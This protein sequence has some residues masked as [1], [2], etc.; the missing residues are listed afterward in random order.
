FDFKGVA[1]HEISEVLG[2]AGLSGG[3]VGGNPGYSLLD[4][5]SYTGPGTKMLGE[6]PN[7]NFSIDNG[8]TLL[9]VFNDASANGLDSRDWASGQSVDAFNQ[10]ASPGVTLPVSA[11]DL[12]VMDVIGYDPVPVPEPA[13]VLALL[14]AALGIAR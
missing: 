4:N 1:A 5:F 10:F 6:G 3:S 7:S 13:G 8:T 14:V 12:Q 11:V 2:R 9:R